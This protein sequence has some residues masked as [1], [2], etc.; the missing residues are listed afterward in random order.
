SGCM[1]SFIIVLFLGDPCTFRMLLFFT[2]SLGRRAAAIVSLIGLF[3]ALFLLLRVLHVYAGKPLELGVSAKWGGLL[4]TL[5]GSAVAYFL[6]G[7]NSGIITL[8]PFWVLVTDCYLLLGCFF[9]L[10]QDAEARE[11]RK[12]GLFFS[13]IGFLVFAQIV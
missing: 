6:F 10:G 11:D 2:P 3:T 1:C 5:S 13:L 9:L 8:V 4:S 12:H 7:N